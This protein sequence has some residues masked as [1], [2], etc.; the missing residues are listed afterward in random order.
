MKNE[1]LLYN[2]DLKQFSQENGFDGW[3]WFADGKCAMAR[4]EED[5]I[6]VLAVDYQQNAHRYSILEFT[7]TDEARH[8]LAQALK[9]NGPAIYELSCYTKAKDA[10]S[11]GKA[12]QLKTHYVH[13]DAEGNIASRN[14]V[15]AAKV[16]L[17]SEWTKQKFNFVITL[18]DKN[19]NG[20]EQELDYVAV[21]F[22]VVGN[23]EV[24]VMIK[25]IQIN[26]V[27]SVG[28]KD[29]TPA[30]NIIDND[31]LQLGAIRW[32]VWSGTRAAAKIN[33]AI[34]N[35][36]KENA[37]NGTKNAGISSQEM[38]MRTLSY[39][40]WRAPYFV[41]YEGEQTN[42][43]VKM[44]MNSCYEATKKTYTIDDVTDENLKQ[45][46]YPYS[47]AITWEEEAK[48]AMDAGID[49]FA[50]LHIALD[51][52][53]PRLGDEP[54]LAHA[55]TNGMLDDG[56]QMKMVCILQ[57]DYTNVVD[58]DTL[59]S[60]EEKLASINVI[61]RLIYQAMAQTCYLNVK[62]DK[63]EIPIMH[64]YP[65]AVARI[66]EPG[67]LDY[68]TKEARFYTRYLNKINPKKYHAVDDV[69]YVAYTWPRNHQL[70]DAYLY[71]YLGYD[72]VSK[73][74]I[75]TQVSQ[76]QREETNR[77]LDEKA[78]NLFSREKDREYH[79]IN[80]EGAPCEWQYINRINECYDTKPTSWICSY[81]EYYENYL[82]RIK[83][84][85]E[86]YCSTVGVVD[87]IP[88][89]SLG[90]NTLPRHKTRVVWCQDYGRMYVKTGTPQQQAQQLKDTLD[91]SL[92]YKKLN[93]NTSNS[94][95][96]YAWNEF[97]EGGY[98]QPT[99]LLDEQGNPVKNAD[100]TNKMNTKILDECTKVIKEFREKEAK[101]I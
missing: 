60:D 89:V 83:K 67:R 92:K 98:L 95:T 8:E 82:E 20:V 19:E 101:E 18:E 24:S 86:G 12:V 50:Y 63:G 77:L 81:G 13:K 49:Y 79:D 52:T 2:G 76:E 42:G 15:C 22:V 36:E 33:E 48:M 44:S 23:V 70:E 16:N 51:V 87:Y 84:H 10:A 54:A 7:N 73:Y 45:V 29:L 14:D 71:N 94:V 100:G 96:I 17:G 68:Y 90:Y 46:D 61:R 93:P 58:I 41:N 62:T 88:T 21:E 40:P 53:S 38:M 39:Y 64:V 97:D 35:A 30:H 26:L 9:K 74:A 11:I 27:K 43:D 57:D 91:F 56:R 72:A 37:E 32:D 69:Y 6:P 66:K 4:A 1:N 59:E 31:R 55:A 78:D 25:D 75:S 85:N 34:A 99:I 47:Y 80:V 5:G 28:K 3:V 65:E